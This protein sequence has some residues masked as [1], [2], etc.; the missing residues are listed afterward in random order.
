MLSFEQ[1]RAFCAVSDELHFS[2]AAAVLGVSQPTV[3]KEIRTLERSLGAKLFIR[4]AHG[5]RLTPIGETLREH[6]KNVLESVLEFEKAAKQAIREK[7]NRVRIAASPSVVNRLLPELLRTVEDMDL[8]ITI[9]ALE[10]ETGQV[11]S[12]VETGRSDVGIGHLVGETQRTTKETL[13]HDEI[14][15]VCHRSWA[16]RLEGGSLQELAILP[17]LL[18]PR[19]QSPTYHDFLL[20]ACRERGLDP[21]LLVGTSRISG[22]WSFFLE[23]AR[24]F[25]LAPQDFAGRHSRDPLVSTSLE[26]ALTVP[27]EAVISDRRSQDAQKILEILRDLAR[28]RTPPHS[29]RRTIE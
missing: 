10:V 9:E 19:E 11:V 21:L 20:D 25:A 6:A 17:L 23:D 8:P 12:A 4:S 27:L 22:A 5:T 14:Q 2:R 18:W 7:E 26:P 24:A 29:G 15:L 16:E 1:L 13:G 3:S 28:D